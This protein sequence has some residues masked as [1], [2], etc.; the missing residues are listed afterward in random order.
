MMKNIL[1]SVFFAAAC[2]A[3]V[4]AAVPVYFDETRPI[5]ERVEDALSRMTLDE[6][7]AM[8]HAQSK[9]SSAGVPRLG[10]PEIWTTDGPHG[11]RPEVLWDEWRQ[12]GWTND[13]CT[14]F[15][16]LTCLAATW[17]PDMASLYGRSIGEEAR[18]RKKDMLLGPGVNIY[19]TP[20]NGRN[21]EYMGEDP[22]LAAT[23]VVPYI[24]GVQSNGVAAC[25]KHFALNNHEANRHT[26]NAVVDDRALYEI[27]LPAFRAA[28]EDGGAWA[29]MGS[30]NLYKGIHASHNRHLLNDILKGEWGFDGV[31]VSDWGGAHDT[32]EA[33]AGGLDIE[34]GTGAEY[35]NYYLAKP[36]LDRIK[37][38]RAGTVELDDKV[39]RILRLAFRTNMNTRRP[40]GALCSP[41]HVAAARRIGEEGIVLL[42]NEG[43]VLPVDTERVK[44]IAVIGE[45][46]VKMMTVGGGSSSLKAK[47]EISPLDGIRRRF[48]DKAEVVYARGYVGDTSGEADGVTTGQNLKDS[49]MAAELI[50]E[51]V[52]AAAG[53]DIVIFVGGLNKSPHQDCE[54]TD[55]AGLGLPYGQDELIGALAKA[56]K[57]LVVVNISGNA[58]AMPWIK[59]VPAVVQ[60]WYLG[61]ECGNALA[62]VLSGDVNPSG[63]LPMTFPVAL[64]DVGAHSEGEYP[65]T[66]RADGSNIVDCNYGEGIF[67]GYRRDIKPLFA[68]GHGLSYTTFDYGKPEVSDARMTADG[69]ITVKV[70]VTNTGKRRGAEVVQLYISDIKSSLPRP[71]KELKDFRKVTLEPGETVEVEFEITPDKLAY[72]DD[73]RHEW[74][75]EPGEFRALIGSSSADIR[76]TV[77]FSLSE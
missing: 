30:Y 41:E 1:L 58:V 56:N 39:R 11:I 32:D 60:A 55:R 66:P 72:F 19:R 17:S 6:K 74:V 26:T 49:R 10:I 63:K 53:A 73:R 5:D 14:A 42:K 40:F 24:K 36:Y 16:A 35:D 61:S 64:T 51:A 67:V 20:L 44:K 25:V 15:P 46:A 65:G 2:F 52:K 45:N 12:A 37:D 38:G 75:A 33:I 71:V 68:F 59:S 47:Y 18:Y 28:V 76:R 29:V 57:N 22:Y 23:M 3:T 43:G 48:G 70:P 27:Y 62:S 31:V 13:S 8:L 9:F 69:S 77:S 54:D 34:F 7:I 21:F 4:A 50:D